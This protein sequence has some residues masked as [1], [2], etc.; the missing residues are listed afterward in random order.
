[1]P[2]P[3]VTARLKPLLW[4]AAALYT[5]GLYSEVCVR[6]MSDCLLCC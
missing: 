2:P 3:G 1:M 6:P 5:F 4:T